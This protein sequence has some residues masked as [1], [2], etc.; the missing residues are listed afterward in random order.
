MY[1]NE[2]QRVRGRGSGATTRR[3]GA[4]AA[5]GRVP[6]GITPRLV[7]G[8]VAYCLASINTGVYGK[9]IFAVQTYSLSICFIPLSR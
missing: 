9:L 5:R 1:A 6:R 7:R 3:H 8:G 2:E 4:S